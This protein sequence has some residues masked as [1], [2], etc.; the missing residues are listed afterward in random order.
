MQLSIAS[1][2]LSWAFLAI[3]GTGSQQSPTFFS[4][5][6]DVEVVVTEATAQMVKIRD[7]IPAITIVS[8]PASIRELGTSYSVNLFFSSDFDPKAGE[9][10]IEFSYI[11]KTD[12][13]G[14]SF[15]QR[16]ATFS[17]D[18]KGTAEFIEFGEQVRVRFE[19]EVFDGSEGTEGRR[20]VTVTGEAICARADI[21]G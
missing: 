7:R 13:L 18:T 20:R 1:F 12:T 2:L 6:G 11:R 10:A 15:R 8:A 4:V 17:H 5:S 16:G 19:F 3:A 9:V 21:F 14:A